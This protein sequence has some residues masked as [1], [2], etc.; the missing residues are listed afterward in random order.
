MIK[1]FLDEIEEEVAHETGIRARPNKSR[2]KKLEKQ[3]RREEKGKGSPRRGKRKGSVKR[4]PN[5]E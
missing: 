4:L 1:L 5:S 2:E 3:K